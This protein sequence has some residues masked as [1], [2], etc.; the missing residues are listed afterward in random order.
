MSSVSDMRPNFKED[1]YRTL[2]SHYFVVT[3]QSRTAEYRLGAATILAGIAI[4]YGI[5]PDQILLPED[6]QRLKEAQGRSY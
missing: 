6:V 5:R 2:V 4:T 3:T 1:I